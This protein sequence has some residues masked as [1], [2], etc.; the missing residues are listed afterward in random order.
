[1]DETEWTSVALMWLE[2][3]CLSTV[4]IMEI[5]ASVIGY[6]D[7]CRHGRVRELNKTLQTVKG[8]VYADLM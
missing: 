2:I 4:M 7:N 1:M 8:T 6:D 5:I 3:S